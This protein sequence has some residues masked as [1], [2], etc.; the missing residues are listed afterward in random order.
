LVGFVFVDVVGRDLGG[1][2]EEA[3]RAVAER[4]PLPP[5][6]TTVNALQAL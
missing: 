3:K 2:V 4:V 1:Y 5:G 6:Y